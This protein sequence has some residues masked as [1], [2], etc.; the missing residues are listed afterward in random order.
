MKN[1]RNL[2]V[3]CDVDDVVVEANEEFVKRLNTQLGISVTKDNL[4]PLDQRPERDKIIAF[5]YECMADQSFWRSMNT[6]AGAKEYIPKIKDLGAKLIFSTGRPP[7]AS[8]EL[9]LKARG[10]PFDQVYLARDQTDN[11]NPDNLTKDEFIKTARPS[12]VIEDSPEMI[13]HTLQALINGSQSLPEVFLFN[14]PW[15]FHEGPISAK[16]AHAYPGVNT[17]PIYTGTNAQWKA[18]YEHILAHK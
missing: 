8:T 9:D 3:V 7:E 15:T 13:P 6:I 17:T 4:Y 11:C 2:T 18:I 16:K 10:I 1:R 12:F 14:Q 5:H